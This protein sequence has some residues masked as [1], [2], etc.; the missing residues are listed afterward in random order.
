MKNKYRSDLAIAKNLGS[1]GSGSAHWWHQR[2]TGGVL[3]ISTIWLICFSWNLSGLEVSGIIEVVKKPYNIVMLTL[4]TIAGFYHAA[5]GMR[6]IFEDY[7]Q[8]RAIR[9]VLVLL[10]Q[11]FS[12][13]TI[14]SF[15]MAVMHVM[16]L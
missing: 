12:I 2:V 9:L 1:A 8:C 5:L 13:V 11:I 6:V 7:I 15:I 10:V 16:N 3:A 14:I 4:F